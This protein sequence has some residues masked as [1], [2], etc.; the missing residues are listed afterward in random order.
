MK[1]LAAISIAILSNGLSLSYY[2]KGTS[3]A[4]FFAPL[5][6]VFLL[7]ASYCVFIHSPEN[8]SWNSIRIFHI[9]PAELSAASYELRFGSPS[10][11]TVK[12]LSPAMNIWKLSSSPCRFINSSEEIYNGHL[13]VRTSPG[14]F[15]WTRRQCLTVCWIRSPG[16]CDVQPR[17]RIPAGVP[18]TWPSGFLTL[19]G[20]LFKYIIFI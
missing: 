4:T 15:S 20:A 10:S 9:R 2:F 18:T 14:L 6:K 13:R 12:L 3:L 5:F 19:S 8:P 1:S 16:Q 7:L 17:N 11:R